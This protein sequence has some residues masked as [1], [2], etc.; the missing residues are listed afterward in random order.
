MRLFAVGISHRTAP[1]ELRESV[2]F[3]RRGVD[4]ALAALAERNLAREAVVLSTCNRAE[5]YASAETEAVAE[6]CGR[7]IGEYNGVPWETVAPHIGIYPGAQ[8]ADQKGMEQHHPDDGD[9]AQQ[10]EAGKVLHARRL[11]ARVP[12][13]PRSRQHR[14]RG[15]RFDHPR[16][17]PL[18]IAARA[19]PAPA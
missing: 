18:T 17:S 13:L 6:A 19:A 2:D 1:V 16:G 7:F 15:F 14:Q 5:I 8:A 9:G 12:G 4:S 3:A 11:S 10:V